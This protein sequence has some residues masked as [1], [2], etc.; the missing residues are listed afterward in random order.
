MIVSITS[1]EPPVRARWDLSS[2]FP[3]TR[4]FNPS[5]TYTGKRPVTDPGSDTGILRGVAE[6]EGESAS[7]EVP[8]RRTQTARGRPTGV[9]PSPTD[10]LD[11]VVNIVHIVPGPRRLHI[12]HTQTKLTHVL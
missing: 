11:A 9:T 5:G 8:V 6:A 12:K 1:R 4:V 10:T 3:A 7:S 2:S